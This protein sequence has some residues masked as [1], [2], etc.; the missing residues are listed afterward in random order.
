MSINDKSTDTLTTA[1]LDGASGFGEEAVCVDGGLSLVGDEE[2]SGNIY[3]E[4]ADV[5][6]ITKREIK[7]TDPTRVHFLAEGNAERFMEHIAGGGSA[8]EYCRDAGISVMTWV[9][10]MESDPV[11][12]EDY[13]RAL[14]VRAM[15]SADKQLEIA[16]RVMDG[17]LTSGE[18]T[19]ASKI[20]QWVAS[21]G[22]RDRYAERLPSDTGV[23]NIDMR[24]AIIEARGRLGALVGG[25]DDGGGGDG[26][27]RI[28]EADDGR[29][30]SIDGGSDHRPTGDDMEGDVL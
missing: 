1:G 28:I 9:R 18:A 17:R 3:S 7:P 19:A 10:L 20:H 16:E 25:V 26:V 27:G 21:R 29:V 14:K 15:E 22:D 12:A 8:R 23:V 2:R 6:L 24:G 5:P 11:L 30:V 4:G 13:S